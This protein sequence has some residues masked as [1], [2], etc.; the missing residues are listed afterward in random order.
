MD[1]RARD[2]VDKASRSVRL[3]SALPIASRVVRVRL[4]VIVLV[5]IGRFYIGT[6]GIDPLLIVCVRHAGQRVRVGRGL[7]DRRVAMRHCRL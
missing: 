7:V 3:T 4:D 2:A 5:V 1:E 6:R